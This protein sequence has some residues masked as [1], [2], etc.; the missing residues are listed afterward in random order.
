MK[1]K[2]PCCLIHDLMPLFLEGLTENET[3]ILIEE[4]LNE[5]ES[6]KNLYESM[7]E[8]QMEENENKQVDYLKKV[9]KR[10]KK[11]LIL[12]VAATCFIFVFLIM[13]KLFIIG[14][15]VKNAA[16]SAEITDNNTLKVSLY[17]ENSARCY[18]GT[19]ISTKDK[20]KEIN[21]REVLAS[22]LNRN[23]FPNMEISLD[24]VDE[25]RVF[26]KTVWQKGKLISEDAQNL[27]NDKTPYIGSM[28]NVAK[29]A[30]N[31]KWPDKSMINKLHTEKEPYGWELIY[32]ESLTAGNIEKLEKNA[33]IV[34]CLV[35]NMSEFIYTFPNDEGKVESKV[36]T[37]QQINDQLPQ[38]I[39]HYNKDRSQQLDVNL[40][41]KDFSEST[42]LIEC[43]LQ[44]IDY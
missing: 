12:S 3:K 44:I 6:C 25:V 13:L 32:S 20:I 22:P 19:R 38:L 23:G 5:C 27:Y 40:K 37:E 26:G 21:A 41:I 34:I 8:P 17:N 24:G 31:L 18:S 7:K 4:H 36:I 2:I 14:D 10:S 15:E 35:D 39:E 1:N 29:L 33:P 16:V 30:S 43:L 28:S 11:K 42:Y 9:K